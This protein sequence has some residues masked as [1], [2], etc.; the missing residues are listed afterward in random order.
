M[1]ET[2][3]TQDPQPTIAVLRALKAMGIQFTL[4]DFGTGYSSLSYLKRFQSIWDAVFVCKS[5]PR[6]WRHA[7]DC[8]LYKLE[9]VRKGRATT[10]KSLSRLMSSQSCS[11]PTRLQP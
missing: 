8:W 11:V 10:F 9:I 1:T 5:S 6:A 2:A 7:T 4:D 3:F